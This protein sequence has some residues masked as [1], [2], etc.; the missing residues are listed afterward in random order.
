M[1]LIKE[2]DRI[3]TEQ[4]IIALATSTDNKPNVRVVNFYYDPKQQGIIFFSTF[5]DNKKVSEFAENSKVAFTTVPK[6]GNEHVRVFGG[7]V[8]RSSLTV[9][10]LKEAFAEKIPDYAGTVEQAGEMLDLYEI[11]FDRADVVI[12]MENSGSVT[13]QD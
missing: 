6:E 8:R 3:M 1:N 11:H 13:F 9:Y 7:E 5:K 10:D 2:F 12:D 4:E